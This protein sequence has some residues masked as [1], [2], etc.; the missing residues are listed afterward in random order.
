MVLHSGCHL[1]HDEIVSQVPEIRQFKVGMANVF[2]EYP[3]LTLSFHVPLTR[4]NSATYIGQPYAKRECG[5]H[6]ASRHVHGVEQDCSRRLALSAWLRRLWWYGMMHDKEP[7]V[8]WIVILTMLSVAWTF[9]ERH[10]W[11][12]TQYPNHKWI[13]QYWHLARVSRWF[14]CI[15]RVYV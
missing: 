1:V 15:W 2:C 12:L 3:F 10:R 7:S 6:S 11:C 14:G 9:E 8:G 13:A 5:S 4:L